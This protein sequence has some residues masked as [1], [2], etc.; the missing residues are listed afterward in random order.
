VGGKR[1]RGAQGGDN[2]TKDELFAEF[3]LI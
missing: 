1:S 3:H 2:E